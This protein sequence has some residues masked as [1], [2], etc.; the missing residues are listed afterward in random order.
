MSVVIATTLQDNPVGRARLATRLCGAKAVVLLHVVE[1]DVDA[2]TLACA[3]QDLQ[4]AA[5]EL[6]ADGLTASVAV[7]AGPRV[8]RVLEAASRP[9]MALV[10]V[11]TPPERIGAMVAR[12]TVRSPVPVLVGGASGT[13]GGEP[14]KL[15]LAL[16]GSATALGAARW[17]RG[18]AGAELIGVHACTPGGEAAARARLQA[19]LGEER[20]LEALPLQ[21]AA[22]AA[23][24]GAEAAQVAAIAAGAGADVL[25]LGVHQ[26]THPER[27]AAG[28]V[29]LPLLT[30]SALPVLAV[31]D[32]STQAG[33]PRL[34]RVL[35]PVVFQAAS[36]AAVPWAFSLAG[37]DG[38]VVLAHVTSPLEDD[39]AAIA[40]AEDVE[41]GLAR[42]IPE[43]AEGTRCACRTLF[44]HD[45]I[46]A[47]LREADR[48]A[49]D[50]IV[51]GA[52][53]HSPLFGFAVGSFVTD[54]LA[55]SHRPVF[56][57]RPAER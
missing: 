30:D 54:L 55:A 6:A 38:Y 46:A 9:G 11:G 18:V 14:L 35:V 31:P 22:H 4:A 5:A 20:G 47:V 45:P 16:D 53:A 27:L 43:S 23:R 12:L 56:V 52:E 29:L 28:S 36:E 44:L 26:D 24:A 37:R 50:A 1:D 21:I 25:V 2:V 34:R 57:V 48:L 3:H 7:E 17:A 51:V 19:R 41:R 15:A 32:T 13:P 49:A 42:L 40:R 39:D 10:A 8:E 33:L